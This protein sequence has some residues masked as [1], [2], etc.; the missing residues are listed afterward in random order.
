[1]LRL[2][3]DCCS[4]E[5][6]EAQPLYFLPWARWALEGLMPTQFCAGYQ[7]DPLPKIRTHAD[8]IILPRTSRQHRTPDIHSADIGK[9]R[10]QFPLQVEL[11][12]TSRMTLSEG[13]DPAGHDCI[14]PL[15]PPLR[16][17]PA[18]GPQAVS[19]PAAAE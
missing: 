16:F 2:I 13:V 11:S 4:R 1:M 5:A 6:T 19:C 9:L 17:N 7:N 3:L 14:A 10:R 15:N 12:Y 18:L 8:R